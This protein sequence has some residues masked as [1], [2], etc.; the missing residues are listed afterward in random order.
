MQS[1]DATDAFIK[2]N[3]DMS[4]RVIADELGIAFS[5]VNKYRRQLG[6]AKGSGNGCICWKCGNAYPLKCRWV[7]KLEPVWSKAKDSSG[8]KVVLMCKYFVKE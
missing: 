7:G 3:R 8:V 6:L 1:R 2:N 4:D 5:T